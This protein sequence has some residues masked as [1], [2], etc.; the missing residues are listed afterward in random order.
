MSATSCEGFVTLAELRRSFRISA[1][2]FARWAG[3]PV[4]IS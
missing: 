4:N 3:L 1:A 2:E